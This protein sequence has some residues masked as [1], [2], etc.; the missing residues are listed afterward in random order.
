MGSESD[1]AQ[2]KRAVVA[3]VI[4]RLEYEA[5]RRETYNVVADNVMIAIFSVELDRKATDIADG[6]CAPLFTA[7][8]A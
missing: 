6:V 3:D 8:G 1:L 2:K 7:G 5:K 4:L